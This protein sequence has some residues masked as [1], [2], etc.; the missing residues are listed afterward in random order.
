MTV[1]NQQIDN[2]LSELLELHPKRIDLSLGRI[3]NL[4]KKINEPQSK[5]KN[6]IHVAGTNG[7]YSTLRYLQEILRYNNKTTNAYISPHLIR[8]NERFELKDKQVDNETLLNTLINLKDKNDNDP[9]TFFEITSAAFFELASKHTA[10]YTLLE[11][12]LGG[13]LDSSNVINPLISV[14]SSISLDHQDFLGDKIEQIAFEKSGIIKKNVPVVIGYQPYREAKQILI[15]QAQYLECPTFIYG[16]DFF[17]SE[18]NDQLIYE[19][20]DHRI[21][22]NKLK[23]QNGKFQIKNL[24]TAIATCLQLNKVE[25]KDFLKN[26]L[27]Q[28]VYFPGRFEKLENNKLN[29]LISDQNELYI[30]GSH[31]QD[32]SKNINDALKELPEKKLC[33]IVGMINTKDPLRYVSEYDNFELLTTITIPDEENSYSADDLKNIFLNN[34]KNTK[35]SNSIEEAVKSTAKAFP[36]ARILICGSLYL[37]G[38]VLELS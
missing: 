14:I 8:F 13:R 22:F 38:K 15:D 32:G 1:T 16:Y 12:G 27:H 5:I 18:D 6:I 29:K 9:I 10:D 34:I 36:D 17:I 33:L 31:N 21:K 28:K 23:N 11:V 2:I 7:K 24:A 3:I 35:Q 19:D 4:L 37:A 30:D 26:D 25:V 20:F